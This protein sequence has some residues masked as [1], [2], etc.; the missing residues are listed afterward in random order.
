MSPQLT[1]WQQLKTRTLSVDRVRAVDALAIEKYGMH[2]LVLMENAAL[3]CVDWLCKK[4]R[5]PQPTTILCGRG[6]NGGDGLAIA[7]HLTNHGWPCC[8]I[9]LGPIG[10]LSSDARANFRILTTGHGLAVYLAEEPLKSEMKQSLRNSTVIIDALLGTGAR[11]APRAPLDDWIDRA[12]RCTA[13][14]TAIDIPTGINAET[15]NSAG[16]YFQ[17]DATL[18]FVARKPAMN[19]PQANSIFGEIEVLPIGIPAHMMLEILAQS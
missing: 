16:L 9:Q 10:E 2:S 4:F 3:G 7:R 12:N 18:T 19:H 6:N 13:F 5:S 11:G 8:V 14:R 15:G 1:A 17:A